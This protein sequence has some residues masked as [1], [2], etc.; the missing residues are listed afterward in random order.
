MDGMNI[1]MYGILKDRTHKINNPR[2]KWYE[3]WA[4]SR[5]HRGVM[6]QDQIRQLSVV[7]AGFF[8]LGE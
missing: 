1:W 8:D 3:Y 2:V 6:S 7:H 5:K 4:E